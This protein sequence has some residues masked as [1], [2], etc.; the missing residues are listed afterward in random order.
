MMRFRQPGSSEGFVMG[1]GAQTEADDFG[2]E[3][4]AGAELFFEGVRFGLPFPVNLVS[5]TT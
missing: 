3:I 2:R 4:Q 5:A 1:I